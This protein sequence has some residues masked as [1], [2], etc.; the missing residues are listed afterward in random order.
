MTIHRAG[1]LLGLL[2][3][4]IL[5]LWLL[6]YGSSEY[7]YGDT[8]TFSA[9]TAIA[10]VDGRLSVEEFLQISNGHRILFSRLVTAFLTITTQWDTRLEVMV[11]VLLAGSNVLLAVA[12]IKKF[13]P[14]VVP[15]AWFPMSLL[16][17][18]VD[19]MI[20]WV[21][22]VQSLWHFTL[23]CLLAN[24]NLLAGENRR[25]WKMGLVIF[26]SLFATFSAGNGMVIWACV[27]GA[28]LIL[29]YDE[30]LVGVIVIIGILAVLGYLH[31]SGIGMKDQAD[32]VLYG[33]I[34]IANPQKIA[35]LVLIFIGRPLADRIEIAPLIGLG[36]VILLYYALITRQRGVWI[37]ALVAGYS[38]L[39]ALQI[40]LTRIHH[41]DVEVGFAERYFSISIAFWVALCGMWFVRLANQPN[42]NPVGTRLIASLQTIPNTKKIRLLPFLII[43]LICATHLIALSFQAG[44]TDWHNPVNHAMLEG[45]CIRRY[46]I[47]HEGL[48]N[49]WIVPDA[50]I[51]DRLIE[52][53]LSGFARS[54]FLPKNDS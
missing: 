48:C 34:G 49:G 36:G 13:A 3:F 7:P 33:E 10:T 18:S 53:R 4:I 41:F 11:N 22:G 1:K 5:V 9:R 16:L 29:R 26:L 25:G 39:S 43:L 27:V 19:Q 45:E 54:A 51:T 40:A 35:K 47:T 42:Q 31:D 44:R 21:S 38:L 50:A 8:Y 52:R 12:L 2:P 20:N 23:F 37:W 14:S 30:R 15:L 17:L 28:M 46:P 32:V 24:L 6:A